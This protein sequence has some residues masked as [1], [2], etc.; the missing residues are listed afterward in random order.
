M[1]GE[2]SMKVMLMKNNE[3]SMS[4]AKKILTEKE[5]EE[6]K[7]TVEEYIQFGKDNTLGQAWMKEL[8][9]ASARVHIRRLEAL[10]IQ[11]RQ[12]VETL[13]QREHEGLQDYYSSTL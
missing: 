8:G 10:E 13:Y 7:W 6:F 2:L 5:L 3:I 12:T 1:K 4:Q 11:L 9:N